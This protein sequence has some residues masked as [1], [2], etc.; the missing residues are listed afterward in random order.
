MLQFSY[1]TGPYDSLSASLL[2]NRLYSSLL[3][4]LFI[5]PMETRSES[6]L[7]AHSCR[8]MYNFVQSIFVYV[9]IGDLGG[10]ERNLIE[11]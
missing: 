6:Y 1:I 3:S 2:N 5:H 11:E 7:H 9:P 10:R 8:L 4:F